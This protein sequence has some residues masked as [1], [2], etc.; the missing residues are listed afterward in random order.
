MMKELPSQKVHKVRTKRLLMRKNAQVIRSA[1]VSTSEIISAEGQFVGLC[2]H[3]L[4]FLCGE[5]G[6]PNLGELYDT[7]LA[8]KIAL[9]LWV[10][11]CN[12]SQSSN[13]FRPFVLIG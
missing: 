3:S 12:S 8:Q 5:N 1:T 2:G 13:F 6:I 10:S 7:Q 4:H 11:L 9:G